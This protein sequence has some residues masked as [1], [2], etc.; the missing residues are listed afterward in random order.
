[1]PELD[2][3]KI[4]NLSSSLLRRRLFKDKIVEIIIRLSGLLVLLA[5]L[6]IFYV[7][8]D[9][10]YPLL[11]KASINSQKEVFVK[12]ERS[13]AKPLA[14]GY[15]TEG[16]YNYIWDEQ[17]NL[18]YFSNTDDSK[19]YHYKIDLAAEKLSSVV[20]SKNKDYFYISDTS[21][22]LFAVELSEIASKEE[23]LPQVEI[24]SFEKTIRDLTIQESERQTLFAGFLGEAKDQIQLFGIF[25]GKGLVS[26]VKSKE[27]KAQINASGKEFSSLEFSADGKKL[28]LGTS[29]GEVLIYD[30]SNFESPQLISSPVLQENAKVTAMKFL[31]QGQTLVIGFEN[32]K[33]IS[34][35]IEALENTLTLKKVHQ[36]KDHLQA[37]RNIYPSMRNRMFLSTDI[38]GTIAIHNSTAKQTQYSQKNEENSLFDLAFSPR[39]NAMVTLDQQAN[40]K[41]WS[42]ENDYTDVSLKTLFTRVQYEGY[43]K[44]E[45]VWQ[46]SSGSDEFEPKYNLIPLIFGTLKGTLYA[47]LFAVPIAVMGA[48]YVSEFMKSEYRTYI[49]PLVELMAAVP[50]VVI[51]FMAGIWLAPNLD[52][53]LVSLLIFPFICFSLIAISLLIYVKYYD[54]QMKVRKAGS[55]FIF[56]LLIVSLSVLIA[57]VLSDFFENFLF[58]GSLTKILLEKFS[59]IYDQRNSLVVSMAMGYAIIPLIF[60]LAEDSI[61]AVPKHLREGSLALGATQWQ[62]AIKVVFPAASPGIFS[63]ILLGFGRAI[64]E[65]MIVLMATGNT[66]I[67]D[68]SPFNGFRALSANIAVE[69]PEATAGGPLYRIIFLS[70]FLLLIFSFFVNTLTE[71]IRV[72]L[73]KKYN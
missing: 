43:K 67:I 44:K 71:I 34:Y 9:E 46:S 69:L 45:Y 14:L 17:G 5:I 10:V 29:L 4:G 2:P 31:I 60:T 18:F 47:L 50:S 35:L 48:L 65:T 64:G 73:R 37:V 30:L 13:Q 55:E 42:I 66:P 25:K 41:S 38:S 58:S 51:G 21:G 26:K 56:V 28:F 8:L 24:L 72:K 49:K 52:D 32:G 3:S 59:I 39:G 53:Y 61:S 27:I 11:K 19:K 54:R 23:I 6:G 68:L 7:I 36:F 16:T 62:T 1:M 22:K 33:I 15:N 40:F 63:A 12:L 70:S 57:L 20:K